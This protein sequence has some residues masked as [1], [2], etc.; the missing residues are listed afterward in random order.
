MIGLGVYHLAEAA[1]YIDMPTSTLR[2]WF[3]PRSESTRPG[4]IFK[5]DY[6]KVDGAYAIS[7][8]N[9][10]D[11]R[12]ALLF[13]RHGVRPSI[14][15]QAHKILQRDMGTTHPFAR[16]DLR[17]DGS[18]IIREVANSIGDPELSDVITRQGF[19]GEMK[20]SLAK[21]TYDATTHLASTWGLAEGV[22][23]DPRLSFGKPVVKNTGSTTFVV[24]SQYHANNK[25][26]AL[27]SR[28]FRISVPEVMNAVRFEAEMGNVGMN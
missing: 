25:D 24:A 15:R 20:E 11:A 27:V 7:F 3:R 5:S 28:L 6:A 1:R 13:R 4:P 21:V 18:H 8:L 12:F 17:T 23:L 16:A 2:S 19:F 26:S 22:V 10:M 14:I 9:L